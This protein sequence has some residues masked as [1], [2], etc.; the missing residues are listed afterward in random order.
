MKRDKPD[1]VWL[2][3]E[4]KKYLEEQAR[5]NDRSQG[6]FLRALFL[7][8]RNFHHGWHL[9][10][11]PGGEFFR[12]AADQVISVGWPRIHPGSLAGLNLFDPEGTLKPHLADL[13]IYEN[14]Q[15]D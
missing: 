8:D 7:R 10:V 15:N 14:P 4:E 3:E 9:T 6:G 13:P 12:V 11:S 2:S 1:M 5:E